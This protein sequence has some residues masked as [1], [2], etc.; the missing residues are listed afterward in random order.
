MLSYILVFSFLGILLVW[1]PLRFYLLSF[2]WVLYFRFRYPD[3]S[4]CSYLVDLQ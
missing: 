4:G 1:F 2:I 3:L